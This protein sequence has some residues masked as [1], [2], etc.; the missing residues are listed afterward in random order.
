MIQPPPPQAIILAGPNGSGKSTSALAL[1]PQ[2]IAFIN[3]DKIAQEM[4]GKPSS[5]ADIGAGRMLLDRVST[6]EKERKDFAIETTLATK[7]LR[8]RARHWKR[9]GYQ[10]HLVY[11]LLASPDL[12]VARVAARVRD[13]GHDVPE[14]TIRRRYDAGLRHLFQT[15]LPGSRADVPADG[16]RCFL[17]TWRLYENSSLDGPF[18]VAFGGS[19]V[20]Q[21]DVW[22]KLEERYGA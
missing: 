7:M 2:G 18:L 13:G 10:V 17:D 19:A 11:F 5:A 15:Y 20:T 6:L 21:P 14:D 22:H 9:L 16:Q 3:A 1:L 8:D 4:S 12:A